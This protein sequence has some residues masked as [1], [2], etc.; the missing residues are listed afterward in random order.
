MSPAPAPARAAHP[1]E[2]LFVLLMAGVSFALSQTLV[3]PALPE[4]GDHL[5]AS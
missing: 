2:V 1:T 3:I 5:N 4:I